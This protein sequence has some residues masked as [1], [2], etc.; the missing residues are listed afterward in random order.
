MTPSPT[1]AVNVRSDPASDPPAADGLIENEVGKVVEESVIALTAL[2]DDLLPGG[3]SQLK[4]DG[5]LTRHLYRHRLIEIIRE[6]GIERVDPA[7]LAE[8]GKRLDSLERAAFGVSAR[9]RALVGIDEMAL[10]L[11]PKYQ[12]SA[13]GEPSEDWRLWYRCLAAQARG[14]AYWAAL[15]DLARF[16]GIL[17]TEMDLDSF[18]HTVFSAW[19]RSGRKRPTAKG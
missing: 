14:D 13:G 6:V 19:A 11:A 10:E 15:R 1:E 12:E 9:D 2:L 5:D 4:I 8:V 17:K 16:I 3:M 7:Q 18:K